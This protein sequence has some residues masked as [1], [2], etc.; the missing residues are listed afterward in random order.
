MIAETALEIG[1]RKR[2][3]CGEATDDNH[4]AN[5]KTVEID[6]QVGERETLSAGESG[7]LLKYISGGMLKLDG[8]VSGNLCDHETTID[9]TVWDSVMMPKCKLQSTP[10]WDRRDQVNLD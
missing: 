3:G 1:T 4:L 8:D 7:G 5:P 2:D 6:L 9:F 10:N